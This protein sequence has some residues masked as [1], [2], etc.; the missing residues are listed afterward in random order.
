MERFYNGDDNQDDEKDPYYG[1]ESEGEA[2]AEVI[3]YMDQKGILDVMH[4]DLAQS[5]LNQNLLSQALEIAS[6]SWFWSFK[7]TAKKMTEIETIYQKLFSML[8]ENMGEIPQ[9]IDEDE[10]EDENEER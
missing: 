6:S 3:G 5:E 1:S 10:D 9:D 7:N 2:E 8:G 4:M